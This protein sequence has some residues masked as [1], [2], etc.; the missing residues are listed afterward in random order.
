VTRDPVRDARDAGL[1][2][3]VEDLGDWHPAALLAE[4]DARAKTVRVNARALA[5]ARGAARDELLRAAV[6]H[7]LHHHRVACGEER[8]Q[9]TRAAEERAADAYAL[10]R[11]GIDAAQ[12]V[13]NALG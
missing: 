10:R 12:A 2:V 3:H 8:P 6:A 11:Y 1:S 4:Y 7:E 5:P 13:K 9:R